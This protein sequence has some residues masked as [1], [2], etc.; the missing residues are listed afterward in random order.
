[1]SQLNQIV[2]SPLQSKQTT[3]SRQ[4]EFFNQLWGDLL[5][6]QGKWIELRYQM[7]GDVWDS[8]WCPSIESLIEEVEQQ[9][10]GE[11]FYYGVSLRDSIYSGRFENISVAACLHADLDFKDQP[12]EEIRKKLRVFPV[13][14]TVVIQ[15]G[16]GYHA[17]WFFLKPVI[18]KNEQQKRKFENVQSGLQDALEADRTHDLARILRV[19]GSTNWKDPENGKPVKLL[20][21]DY[22]RHYDLN[23][24]KQFQ[25]QSSIHKPAPPVEDEIPLGTRNQ[26]LASLAGTMRRR[27]MG[28]NAI[29]R[30]LSVT[31]R[32][33][34]APPLPEEEVE[35]IAKSI[36]QYEPSESGN[37]TPLPPAEL[38]QPQRFNFTDQG[39]VRRL[40]R[41]H[42][43][44]IKYVKQWGFLI[45]D[46]NRWVLDTTGEIERR[47]KATVAN[48]YIE[49]ANEPDEEKR[50]LIVKHALKSESL[51][52][53][54]AIVEL[55]KSE[56]EIA[57]TTDQFDSDPMLLNVLNGT[58][59]LRTG[60]LREHRRQ[61]RIT[62]LAPVEYNG[63]QPTPVFDSFIN[64]IMDNIEDLIGF[65]QRLIGYALTGDT[66]EEIV[67]FFWGT[68]Q[69]GKTK[70]IETFKFIL[71]DYAKTARAESLMVKKG[72]AVPEDIA[73]LAGARLVTASE[74][75]KNANLAESL[76]KEI[77]GGDTI[78]ARFLFKNSFEFRP[79][80]T[81]ILYTN[82]KPL[83]DCD[84]DG[85]WR[86]IR[87][88][89]FTVTIPE[90]ERD[91]ELLTKLIAEASGILHWAVQ[92]CLDWQ[93][94]GL[95]EPDEVRIAT[96]EYRN[97]SDILG[98][99]LNDR[100]VIK[101][102]ATVPAQQ[103]Y[104]AYVDWCKE[105][106]EHPKTQNSL[107]RMLTGREEFDRVKVNGYVTY[108]GIGLKM[109]PSSGGFS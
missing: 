68:G 8:K 79:E 95:N 90:K 87:L 93:R 11:N 12:E 70:F 6:G 64:R 98:E 42:F 63:E 80:F 62:K 1:M 58:I 5:D 82:Y 25:P 47:A 61:D 44:E 21:T 23:D 3:Q 48:I 81:L 76:V 88:I 103:L 71:G 27:G 69:N 57:A 67:A 53:M 85:I 86:R 22:S 92:G 33:S 32:E 101:K 20:F 30:A 36:C 75:K 9:S 51:R 100:C 65:L 34:C 89:P 96:E 99:F 15:S 77:T 39:N 31:N 19:P 84:D 18:F 107:G 74:S 46:G 55:A 97:E 109:L 108:L 24:F 7:E 41:D 4:F 105:N 16:N 49:A 45:W 66:R 43:G 60:Q 78:T 40:V 94:E 83:I 50:K 28:V 59:G 56:P 14:P 26:T 104:V 73:R 38:Q 54:K 17:Y 2:N 29:F 52:G 13:P 72:N 37:V 10:K 102:A 35:R 91:K 106:G